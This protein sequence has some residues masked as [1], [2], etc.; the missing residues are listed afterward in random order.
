MPND[1][2]FLFRAQLTIGMIGIAI[3]LLTTFARNPVE[4]TR[5]E[6]MLNKSE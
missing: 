6:A 3:Q 5:M 1:P 4:H 2:S